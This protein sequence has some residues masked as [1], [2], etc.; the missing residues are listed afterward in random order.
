MQAPTRL[1][2]VAEDEEPGAQGPRQ[3]AGA[4]QVE[5]SVGGPGLQ[6]EQRVR[7]YAAQVAG[8]AQLRGQ[9]VDDPL[10]QVA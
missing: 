7:I 2:D 8:A 5:G 3:K 6:A 9:Q 1:D 4:I 10:A